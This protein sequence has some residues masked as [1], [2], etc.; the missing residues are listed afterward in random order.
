MF[1]AAMDNLV[2]LE[3]TTEN[4]RPSLATTTDFRVDAFVGLV[5]GLKR[6]GVD[7][8]VSKLLIQAD[9]TED[10][11]VTV[12]IFLLWANTRDVRGGKGE[13]DL[14]NWLLIEISRR[15]PK[16][17]EGILQLVPEYGSWRDVVSLIN[18]EGIS[19]RLQRALVS[20]MAQQLVVDAQSDTP[21][22]LCA[23]WAP[24][25]KSAHT[26]VA[27]L[28]AAAI[29]PDLKH[30]MPPYRKMIAALNRRL[31]TV[32][33]KM[34]NQ[35]WA[36]INPG[37]VP[38]RCL[39]ICRRAFMNQPLGKK[40]RALSDFRVIDTDR[41]TC[42]RNFNRHATDAI[43]NPSAARL[44]G[45]VLHPHELVA[46][47]MNAF[48]GQ[49]AED[50]LIIEAQWVDLIHRLRDEMP[51]LG[52]MIPLVDVSGSMSGT[53]MEVAVALG[54]IISELGAIKDR[55]I[56]FSSTPRWHALEAGSS[57]RQKVKS[58]LSAHWEMS[59]NFQAALDLVL[60]SCIEGDVPPEEIGLLSLVV[61]SDMQFDNAN[62]KYISPSAHTS[63]WETQYNA[64]VDSF[65]AAGLKSKFCTPYPIPRVIFWNLRGDTKDV[66][67]R[68]DTPGVQMVSGFSPNMLKLLME[69]AVNELAE[70][71]T[72]VKVDPYMTMRTALDDV[73]Y[74]AVRKVCADVGEAK[75]KRYRNVE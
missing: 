44:H 63:V 11:Q 18:I 26:M 37:A 31:G 64:L 42:A 66:P 41:F 14:A 69:G 19:Q 17:V 29:F 34:C 39:K 16:T 70:V 5:R 27:K 8:Y 9:S 56:T 21:P 2:R 60:K 10:V 40:A 33:M 3:I 74:A 55:F 47:Y 32:E 35:E 22:S 68:A 72:V 53:P 25:P 15:F 67:A 49:I 46:T 57:L 61:L 36:S 75:M 43:E 71:G 62:S 28:V 23:K 4:G 54:L 52:Q 1:A 12:D 59:T 58:A 24:R 6:T 13:R 45:R 7:A 48:R 65:R 30:P 50:D 38:A 20:L 73:R 51:A